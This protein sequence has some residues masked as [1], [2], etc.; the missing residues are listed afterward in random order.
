MMSYRHIDL[1]ERYVIHKNIANGKSLRASAELL[2]RSPS[3]I[4]RELKRNCGEYWYR[5]KDADDKSKVRRKESKQRK[6]DKSEDLRD[7][8]LEKLED[9]FSPDSIAGRIRLEGLETMSISHESIYTWLYKEARNGGKYHEYLPGQRKKRQ[10]R[11]KPNKNRLKIPN[12]TGIDERPAEIGGREI[13]GHWEGDTV[14]GTAASGYLATV[15]ERKTRF[16]ASGFMKDKRAETCNRAFCEAFANIPNSSIKSI[17]FDNGLEFYHHE[18]LKELFECNTFFADPYSPWQRG[19]NENAN[20]ILRRF[21]PKKMNFSNLTQEDVD[22]AVHKINSI[23]RK[24]LG[25]YTPYEA[26]LKETVALQT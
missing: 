16:L 4:S 18:N 12:R 10:N 6:L 9:G 8:V 21:F 2:G 11:L 23:P 25:Y 17:T 5:P 7:F 1:D 13:F 22:K 20:R 26:F 24:S 14:A 15:V 19:S 3:S